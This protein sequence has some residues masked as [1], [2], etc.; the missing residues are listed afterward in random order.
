M[1]ATVM[2]EEMI[3]DGKIIT[4]KNPGDYVVCNLASISL[5][6]TSTG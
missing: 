3:K 4:Y 1:S 6:R 2:E 5:A